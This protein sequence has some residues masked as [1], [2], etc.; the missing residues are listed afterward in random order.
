MHQRA[1]GPPMHSKGAALQRLG[2]AVGVVIVGETWWAL[3]VM[4]SRSS[5]QVIND[6][7]RGE[8]H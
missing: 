3:S 6:G 4:S 1:E 7:H 5:A 8:P 2:A